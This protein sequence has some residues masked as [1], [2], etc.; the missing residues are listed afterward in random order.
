MAIEALKLECTPHQIWI[1]LEST[2]L[3]YTVERS[4][5][6]CSDKTLELGLRSRP[7]DYSKSR[8]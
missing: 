3:Y 1:K 4:A 6:S 5:G 7:I 8:I 2:V